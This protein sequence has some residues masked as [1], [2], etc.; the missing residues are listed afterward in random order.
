MAG[1]CVSELANVTGRF[2]GGG[3]DGAL[4]GPVANVID[5]LFHGVR[6]RHHGSGHAEQIV[7]GDRAISQARLGYRGNDALF[8]L[9]PGPAVGEGGQ[10]IEFKLRGIDAPEFQV[11]L[12]DLQPLVIGG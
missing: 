4:E 3:A 5:L 8:H 12:E 2:G 6:E 10:L 1:S 7:A 11:Y 9:G